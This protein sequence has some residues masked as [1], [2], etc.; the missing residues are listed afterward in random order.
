MADFITIT[1][2]FSCQKAPQI[3]EFEHTCS[4]DRIGRQAAERGNKS[5]VAKF[6]VELHHVN[7]SMVRCCKK[8]YLA[9]VKEVNDP[10][11][12]TILPPSMKVSVSCSLLPGDLDE[13]VAAYYSSL[14]TIGS[15]PPPQSLVYYLEKFDMH[16][17]GSK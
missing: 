11:L 17:F 13:E 8:I 5:A 16:D 3:T 1:R 15:S 10:V 2:V 12:V 7:E 14:A 9:K 6:T 4:G